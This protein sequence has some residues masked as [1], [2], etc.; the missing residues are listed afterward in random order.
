MVKLLK[1]KIIICI[2]TIAIFSNAFAK[3]KEVDIKKLSEALGH[4]IGKN[5][6]DLGFKLDLK[7]M[8]KG[9]KKG[10]Q[11]KLSPMSEDECLEA[12]AQIQIKENEKITSQNLKEAKDFLI[13]NLKDKDVIEIEKEKLQYKILKSGKNKKVETYHSPIVKM[14]GRYLD[15]K[16]F[17]NSEETINLNETLPALQKAIVGMNL[18]EKRKVFIHPDLI[19]DRN[20]PHLNSLVIFD[21][22]IL[23]LDAKKDPL[24]EIANNK[25]IF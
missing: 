11:K 18:H 20:S 24:A 7:N 22:E 10:S 16:I 5:L 1:K 17:I 25:K 14:T 3:E 21:I 2:F 19:F 15:D 6:D 4:I 12:L 8:L 13:N 9:I 23:D